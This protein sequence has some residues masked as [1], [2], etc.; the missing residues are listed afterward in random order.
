MISYE[1]LWK[2]MKEKGVTTY[3]LIK[4]HNFSS[5]TVHRLRRNS[6]ISTALINDLCSV[7]NCKIDDILVY[8]PDKK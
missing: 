2:T 3:T 1:P 6:G 5:H 4:K 8:I 7:L